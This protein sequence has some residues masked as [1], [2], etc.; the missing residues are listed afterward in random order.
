MAGPYAHL[1]ALRTVLLAEAGIAALVGTR[2]AVAYP[3]GIVN[4]AYP[5]I[6]L[7]QEAGEQ[8]VSLPHTDDPAR[9]RLDVLSQVDADEAA[10]IATLVLRR[11]H[12]QEPTLGITGEVCIKECRQTWAAFPMWDAKLNAW[13]AP[14]RYLVRA[15]TLPLAP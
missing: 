3:W 2:V 14:A 15:M 13:V 9:V 10:Q 1:E 8:A 12:K 7:W 5:L 11:L 6:A 4:A